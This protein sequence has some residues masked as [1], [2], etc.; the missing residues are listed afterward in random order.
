MKRNYVKLVQLRVFVYVCPFRVYMHKNRFTFEFEMKK[1]L[2]QSFQKDL[3][4]NQFENFESNITKEFYKH[5]KQILPASDCGTQWLVNQSRKNYK[6]KKIS[7]SFVTTYLNKYLSKDPR[8]RKLLW[9][10]FQLISFIH[11]S[12]EIHKISKKKILLSGTWY[13]EITFYMQDFLQFIGVKRNT[14]QV[15]KIKSFFVNFYELQKSLPVLTQISENC[16]RSFIPFP[17]FEMKQKGKY[18]TWEISFAMS[19]TFYLYDY[20]FIF[21]VEF[22]KFDG[23]YDE[24]IK[25]ELLHTISAKTLKKCLKITDFLNKFNPSN[26]KKT[27]IINRL[28]ILFD[29]LVKKKVIE[30]KFVF[31]KENGEELRTSKLTEKHFNK[32]SSLTFFEKTRF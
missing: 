18:H 19:E 2:S 10:L 25:T 17:S 16:F 8:E 28:V 13:Y 30:S 12:K 3:F 15:K 11:N 31:K 24:A 29:L 32:W 6:P 9:Q 5:S 27:K 23:K 7:P 20:P 4:S 26:G 22:A 1:R 14:Y 21:P